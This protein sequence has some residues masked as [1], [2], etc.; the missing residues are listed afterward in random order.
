MRREQKSGKFLKTKK[1]EKTPRMLEVEKHL[2]KIKGSK[3]TLEQDYKNQYLNG[4]LGQK[5]LATRW[6]INRGQIFGSLR[7]SRR[8]WV[9]ILNLPKKD[10]S[11]AI[12]AQ[13]RLSRLCEIC[14]DDAPLQKAHWIPNSKGGPAKAWNLIN[15]CGS[16]HTKFD[17][18]GTKE[19]GLKILKTILRREVFK[20]YLNEKEEKHQKDKIY[21]L[22]EKLIVNGKKYRKF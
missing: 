10:T 21:E 4:D 20:I 17:M 8:N 1:G 19:L 9:E 12:L 3:I 16:C 2:K 13:P 22:Y 14:N 7:G 11:K 5:R 18:R 15:L 6:K